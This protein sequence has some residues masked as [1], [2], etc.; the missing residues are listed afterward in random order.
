MA[1]AGYVAATEHREEHRA[2][3]SRL[4][5]LYRT[6]EC[7]SYDTDSVLAFLESWAVEHIENHDKPLGEYL[8]VAD[9]DDE[10]PA[11]RAH[12]RENHVARH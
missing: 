10:I 9:M 1:E 2:I 12:R 6:L 11:P 4:D 5:T 7:G 8:A 3:L